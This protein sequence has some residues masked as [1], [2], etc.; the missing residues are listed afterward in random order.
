[1]CSG[2]WP[3]GSGVEMVQV[4]PLVW[5]YMSYSLLHPGLC[6]TRKDN[7]RCTKDWSHFLKSSLL[8]PLCQE[9][10]SWRSWEL[11]GW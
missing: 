5:K 6:N 10:I 7:F 2:L 3:V 8:Q 1:M 4:F 11:R 9:V